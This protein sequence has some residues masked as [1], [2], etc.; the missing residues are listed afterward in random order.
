MYF[1]TPRTF[2]NFFNIRREL[3]ALTQIDQILAQPK[4][5]IPVR[6]KNAENTF[7]PY[8]FFDVTGYICL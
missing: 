4:I 1:Y 7:L 8:S 6:I 5:I 3:K 2:L